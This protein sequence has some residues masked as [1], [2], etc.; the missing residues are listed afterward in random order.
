[1]I[2]R[3]KIFEAK[4]VGILYHW[5][6]DLDTLESI[7][8]EDKMWSSYGYISFSRNKNLNYLHRGV[9]IIFDGNKM[10]NKW[11]FESHLYAKDNRFKKEAEERIECNDTTWGTNYDNCI[12]GIK[13]YIIGIEVSY[14]LSPNDIKQLEKIQEELIPNVKI[15][16]KKCNCNGCK[17]ATKLKMFEAKQVGI[18]YHWT[19][20]DSLK[21]ILEDDK[22][23]SWRGYISLSRNKKLNYDNKQCKI[24]FDGN[25][26]SNK[27]QFEPYLY[28]KDTQFKKE[29]E[30]RI[31]C[32]IK[33]DD[34]ESNPFFDSNYRDFFG[35]V[36]KI[37]SWAKTTNFNCI[38]NIKNI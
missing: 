24:I 18:L 1:M 15:E 35:K 3:Y 21:G 6:D 7:L 8:L 23:T 29:A 38:K 31:K 4:Q 13:K 32:N 36:P 28:C 26:M 12:V 14:D 34:V 19:D 30:E 33:E 25:K 37:Q 2:T 10:S 5:S 20:I 11:K 16:V 9:K 22:M 27:F 17:N